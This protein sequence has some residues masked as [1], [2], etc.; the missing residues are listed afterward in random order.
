MGLVPATSSS[1]AALLT[2]GARGERESLFGYLQGLTSSPRVTDEEQRERERLYR[3]L[4][5]RQRRARLR[6]P[7]PPPRPQAGGSHQDEREKEKESD[8]LCGTHPDAVRERKRQRTKAPEA[9]ERSENGTE[10]R[11]TRAALDHYGG[12]YHP[13]PR[14]FVRS[15]TNT[16]SSPYASTTS[17]SPPSSFY[18]PGFY[19][20][21]SSSSSSSLPRLPTTAPA[22]A[23]KSPL[24]NAT[25]VG[26][27]HQ[28]PPPPH[29]SSAATTPYLGSYP[30]HAG[31][32]GGDQEPLSV[33]ASA[34][35]LPRPDRAHHFPPSPY[36]RQDRNSIHHPSWDQ[37]PRHQDHQLYHHPASPPYQAGASTL[38]TSSRPPN[39]APSASSAATSAALGRDPVACLEWDCA[40]EDSPLDPSTLGHELQQPPQ[41]QYHQPHH[42]HQIH[43][44]QQQQ[45]TYYH[46]YSEP[47]ANASEA[48]VANSY[49][50]RFGHRDEATMI[51]SAE[52]CRTAAAPPNMSATTESP[53]GG[54][55]TLVDDD[56]GPR[57]SPGGLADLLL[58]YPESARHALQTRTQRPTP[59]MTTTAAA[60]S[61]SS[62]MSAADAAALPSLGVSVPSPLFAWFAGGHINNN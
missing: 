34:S 27:H 2:T 12:I 16:N 9:K 51:T 21:S 15:W 19:A 1:W 37:A 36:S 44:R 13:Q 14:P 47:S 4:I 5:K 25:L 58:L 33:E 55:L 29:W 41:Q 32:S 7:S 6:G 39:P 52:I 30:A 43:H 46:Q 18:D 28:P 60:T 45:Q 24:D 56:Q 62:S 54:A 17:P 59:T 10:A 22:F 35:A 8:G 40:L 38:P 53:R 42:Q 3:R 49:T 57:L 23:Q 61:S 50:S 26:G 31:G 48:A 11:M 20:P